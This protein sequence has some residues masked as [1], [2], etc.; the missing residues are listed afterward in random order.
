MVEV[1]RAVAAAVAESRANERLRVHRL[2]DLPLSQRTHAAIR[3]GPFLRMHGNPTTV[4][5]N[6]RGIVTPTAASNSVP[7][8]IEDEKDAHLQTISGSVSI[9]RSSARSPARTALVATEMA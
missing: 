5:G 8:T 6:A 9:S 7:S 4:D 3:H 2:L 1:Q